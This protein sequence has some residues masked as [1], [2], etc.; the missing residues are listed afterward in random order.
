MP[1]ANSQ[2][3]LKKTKS[4]VTLEDAIEAL[5]FHNKVPKMLSNMELLPNG[6][7]QKSFWGNKRPRGFG[8]FV[9][10]PSELFQVHAVDT[11]FVGQRLNDQFTPC[12]A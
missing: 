11:T 10:W 2:S 12:A 4:Q 3:I 5:D 7:C 8:R 9:C 6:I 1:L